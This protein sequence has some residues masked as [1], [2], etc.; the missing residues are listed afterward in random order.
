MRTYVLQYGQKG[1]NVSELNAYIGRAGTGKSHAMLDEIK[2][3]MKRRS[4]WRSD[5]YYCTDAKHLSIRTRF[6]ERS[7]P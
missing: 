3:K 4:A 5:Y 1:E 7:R 6:R 2:T